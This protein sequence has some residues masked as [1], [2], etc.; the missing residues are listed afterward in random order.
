MQRIG[1]LNLKA[2]HPETLI[3]LA[4]NLAGAAMLVDGNKGELSPRHALGFVTIIRPAP[5]LNINLHGTAPDMNKI[6]VNRHF[7]ANMHRPV[8]AHRINS[9]S[10]GPPSGVA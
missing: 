4:H 7:I 8:E 9:R 2:T 3:V 6:G 1:L 5:G 10:D